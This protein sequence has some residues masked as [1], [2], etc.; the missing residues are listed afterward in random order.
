AL[1]ARDDATTYMLLGRSISALLGTATIPVVFLIAHR[2]AG[3]AAG[4]IGDGLLASAV[5]HLRDSHF[6][7]VDA[8][9]VFFCVATWAAAVAIADDGKPSAYV[10]AGHQLCTRPR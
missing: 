5:L 3:R 8:S 10:T 4:V 6:F 2:L 1:S 9:L 7:T